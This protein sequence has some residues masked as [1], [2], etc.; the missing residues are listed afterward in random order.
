M[1]FLAAGGIGG[2]DRGHH[3]DRD[4]GEQNSACHAVSLIISADH[5][6]AGGASGKEAFTR[7][8]H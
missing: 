4:C 8:W 3:A 5:N 2:R 6:G 1:V 7:L